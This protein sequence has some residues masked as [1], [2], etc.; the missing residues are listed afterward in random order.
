[1]A[2]SAASAPL[3]FFGPDRASACSLS[4]VVNTPKVT[5]TP[6][7]PTTDQ[8]TAAGTYVSSKWA[9]AIG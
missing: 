3:L 1:M 4:S 7:F 9:Q 5:G 2:A 6:V 8:Q